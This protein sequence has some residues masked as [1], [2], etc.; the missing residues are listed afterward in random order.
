MEVWVEPKKDSS[1]PGVWVSSE[2]PPGLKVGNWESQ[3][4]VCVVNVPSS[5]S[6][7]FVGVV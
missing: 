2:T 6:T 5:T 7:K 3:I 1:G 4:L